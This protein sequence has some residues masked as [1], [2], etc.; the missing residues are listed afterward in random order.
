M[1]HQPPTLILPPAFTTCVLCHEPLKRNTSY[2]ACMTCSLACPHDQ[3]EEYAATQLSSGNLHPFTRCRVCH[4]RLQGVKLRD[5]PSGIALPLH[6]SHLG[7]NPPCERCGQPNTELHHWA[8]GATFEDSASWPTSWLCAECHRQ[9]H[10][11]MTGYRWNAPRA[12]RA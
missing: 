10:Q 3:G 2:P 12:P 7:K 4:H 11:R 6:R 1:T 9:W 8:P 5:L